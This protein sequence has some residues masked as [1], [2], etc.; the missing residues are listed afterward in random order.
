[1][2]IERLE[3]LDSSGIVPDEALSDLGSSTGMPARSSIA[4]KIFELELE[5]GSYPSKQGMGPL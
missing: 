5:P 3:D 2:L 4:M 1:M